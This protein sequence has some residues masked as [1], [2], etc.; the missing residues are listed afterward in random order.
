[1]A[2]RINLIIEFLALFNR[3]PVPTNLGDIQE[4]HTNIPSAPLTPLILSV[5]VAYE[6][7]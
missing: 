3:P 2:T 5:P 6:I 1:M 7:G 4:D